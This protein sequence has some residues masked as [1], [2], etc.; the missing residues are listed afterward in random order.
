M[1]NYITE[2]PSFKT[3]LK[4]LV[5]APQDF[6][7]EDLRLA[8]NCLFTP[9]LLS[10]EQVGVLLT[11]FHLHHVERR[12]ELLATAASLLRERSLE[13]V[14]E[15]AEDFVVDIV[16]TGGDGHNLFNVS[17]TAGIVAA[18][19]G[20]RVVKHGNK[21]STSSSGSADLLHALGCRF[22]S[23]SNKDHLGTV[24]HIP[25]SFLLAS[26]YHPTLQ[27]IA[28]FRK[29][30]PFRTIFNVLGPL[31][32]P[33]KPRGMVLG[34]PQQEL[35]LPFAKALREGGVE[36]ALV[37]CG[38][39]G[40]DEIS[41]AGPTWVWELRDGEITPGVLSPDA[42][43]LDAYP[44][45]AVAGGS[46]DE[47]AETLKTLLTSGGDIPS[48]KKPVLDFVLMNA[49]ALLVVA[50]LADSYTAGVKLAYDSVVSG[51]A[52]DALETFRRELSK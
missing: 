48:S 8:F 36:R 17:T 4:K 50:G 1:R 15:G 40:I 44:L 41:C 27:A 10:P 29:A 37:V 6:T 21:A 31:I 52:W 38:Q 13:V 43:G 32:S 12:P 2:I 33:A 35:G 25:F 20:A 24:S 28:P 39:E 11:A 30:I 49:S 34:V 19:A 46:P 7:S 5:D 22:P 26:H 51:N 47:N 23:R 42:F 9:N 3:T 14:V 18:G 45:E 16:G